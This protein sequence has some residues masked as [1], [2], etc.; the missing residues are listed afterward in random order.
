MSILSAEFGAPQQ[1][2]FFECADDGSSVGTNNKLGMTSFEDVPNVDHVITS[3]NYRATFFELGAGDVWTSTSARDRKIVV[4]D[5]AASVHLDGSNVEPPPGQDR[6]PAGTALRVEAGAEMS[7]TL[8]QIELQDPEPAAPPDNVVS[9]A[10]DNVLEWRAGLD[11]GSPTWLV[12]FGAS[13]CAPCNEIAPKF[14]ELASL[15]EEVSF[16]TVDVE[17]GTFCT[18]LADEHQVSVLPTFLLYRGGEVADRFEGADGE[19]LAG[20]LRAH[21]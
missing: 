4:I 5:G 11:A 6:F 16:G 7:A 14:C 19:A 17:G 13:W 3:S 15:H 12:K 1:S 21:L 9:L 2:F 10:N 18:A 20:W 8:L